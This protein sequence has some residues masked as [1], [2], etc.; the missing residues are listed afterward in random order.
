MVELLTDHGGEPE[1]GG[2]VRRQRR[3][4]AAHGAAHPLWNAEPCR[5]HTGG[6]VAA[7]RHQQADDFIEKERVAAGGPL[8]HLDQPVGRRT[9]RQGA[10]HGANGRR[11]QPAQRNRGARARQVA[12]PSASAPRLSVSRYAATMSSGEAGRSR[13]RYSRSSTDG[14]RAACRSSSSSTIGRRTV[15]PRRNADMASSSSSR[16]TPTPSAGANGEAPA[17]PVPAGSAPRR[18]RV[19]GTTRPS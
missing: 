17:P 8:K 5:V 12:K 6:V 9:A 3:Q 15:M 19:R 1:N 11:V 14:K 7:F 18:W 13:S 4:A 2:A 16:S 10:D